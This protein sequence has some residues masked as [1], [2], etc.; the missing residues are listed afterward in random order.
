MSI[1][2]LTVAPLSGLNEAKGTWPG[3]YCPPFCISPGTH[4]SKQPGPPTMQWWALIG[5]IMVRFI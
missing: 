3:Q 5:D 1:R 4:V 2:E